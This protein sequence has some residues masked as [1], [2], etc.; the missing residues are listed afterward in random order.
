M[1]APHM[2]R[3]SRRSLSPGKNSLPS[4]G[5][6]RTRRASP[7]TVTRHPPHVPLGIRNAMV[8]S[9]GKPSVEKSN[10]SLA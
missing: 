3:R 5:P 10:S 4:I 6:L 1:A 8:R 7:T 2:P 9:S